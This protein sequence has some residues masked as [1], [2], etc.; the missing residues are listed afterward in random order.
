[1]KHPQTIGVIEQSHAAPKRILK[2][3]TDENW[4][5][6]YRS[7]DLATFIHNT[8]H[9][10]S[11]RCTRS[12]L[13]HGREPFKPID[14]RF[15]SH[16]IA[17]KELTS[18]YLVDLQDSSLEQFS[19][20]KSILLK[21][22]HKYRTFYDKKAAAKPF[23]N[24]QSC[25]LLNPSLLTQSDFAAKT[26]TIWL[27]LYKVEKNFTKSKYLIKKTGTPYTQCVH[28]I[29]LR[30]ITPKYEVEDISVTTDDFCPDPSLGK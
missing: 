27:S 21:A 11:I 2:L 14:L 10:S 13:F 24:Q 1:M 7:V 9:H 29:R 20:T 19:H 26:T 30:P 3:N 18:N 17:K 15:R 16:I 4:N 23:T 25:L 6:W 5:T 28:R 8:L 22:Y 12:S